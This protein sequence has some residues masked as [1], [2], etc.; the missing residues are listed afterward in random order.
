MLTYC[1]TLESYLATKR[2]KQKLRQ[3]SARLK[4]GK[5]KK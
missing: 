5:K 1:D 2:T 3:A 4:K